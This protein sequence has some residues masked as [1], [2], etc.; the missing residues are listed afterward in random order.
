MQLGSLCNNPLGN[1]NCCTMLY[2]TLLV[3]CLYGRVLYHFV[4]SR[5]GRFPGRWT[6]TCSHIIGTASQRTP[7]HWSWH[8]LARQ[9]MFSV[10]SD[11][12]ISSSFVEGGKCFHIK[13]H[14]IEKM[15]LTTIKMDHMYNSVLWVSCDGFPEDSLHLTSKQPPTNF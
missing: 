7:F 1:S 5:S 14:C 8:L 12:H 9:L 3:T 11:A 4:S 6:L 13:W 10:T 2:G 15:Y